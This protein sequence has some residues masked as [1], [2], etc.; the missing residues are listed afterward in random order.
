M[1]GLVLAAFLLQS[2]GGSGAFAAGRRNVDPETNMNIVSGA[3]AARSAPALSAAGLGGLGS[4]GRAP[5]ASATCPRPARC[6]SRSHPRVTLLFLYSFFP[7]L[8]LRCSLYSFFLSHLFLF[9]LSLTFF[10]VFAPVFRNR[11]RSRCSWSTMKFRAPCSWVLTHDCF[12]P[13]LGFTLLTLFSFC[14]SS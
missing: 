6:C 3:A 8:L 4:A 2:I 11:Y 9:I 13:H 10:R 7:V 12:A 5:A 1:R 14:C